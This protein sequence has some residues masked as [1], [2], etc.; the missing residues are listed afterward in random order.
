MTA[1]TGTGIEGADSFAT[2]A[3]ADAYHLAHGNTAWVAALTAAKES[4]LVRGSAYVDGA[5]S[6][7]GLRSSSTQGLSWPRDD[8]FDADGLELSGVPARVKNAA[9]EAALVELTPG[10]LSDSREG[11]ITREKVGEV[12]VEYSQ[13]QPARESWPAIRRCLRGVIGGSGAVRMSR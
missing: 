4:A 2:V 7:P 11:A 6:W 12:E 1:E 9:C 3:E 13:T 5:F 10:T 8:A